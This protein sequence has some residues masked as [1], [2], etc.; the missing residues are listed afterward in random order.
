MSAQSS[1]PTPTASD[2]AANSNSLPKTD[3]AAAVS[4]QQPHQS[5]LDVVGTDEDAAAAFASL[6]ASGPACWGPLQ[7]QTLHQLLRGYP[8]KPT[9][10]HKDALR[11][12]TGALARLIPCGMCATHW[13]ALAPTVNT[14]SRVSAM[15]WAVDVHNTVN[16]RLHKPVLTYAQAAAA[17]A[18][19]CPRNG[20][21]SMIPA[22]HAAVDRTRAI[23]LI[24][25]SL[26]A[27]AAV[28]A[29]AVLLGRQCGGSSGSGGGGNAAGRARAQLRR[30]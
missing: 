24:A 11:A 4:S 18:R 2:S 10:Q 15:K 1:S 27:V 28:I 12:Y 26:V 3:G 8:N 19:T 30:G 20:S 13:A 14:D 5:Q 23:M 22:Q 9:Q 25:I 29:L 21:P 6:P 7:W 16:K 17:M